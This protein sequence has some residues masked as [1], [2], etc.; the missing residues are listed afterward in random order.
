MLPSAAGDETG[1]FS[2][3]GYPTYLSCFERVTDGARTRDL[4]S[5]A[6][7]RCDPLQSVLVRPDQDIRL[8]AAVRV[9]E[10]S[11]EGR[12]EL[13]KVNRELL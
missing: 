13:T 12:E 5:S 1:G 10:R 9:L 7:I 8:L 2:Y 11:E 3:S 6:T 4:L